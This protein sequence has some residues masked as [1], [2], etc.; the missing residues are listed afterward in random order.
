MQYHQRE[1]GIESEDMVEDLVEEEWKC[2]F[3][4]ERRVDYLVWQGE[5]GE[6]IRCEI[7]GTLYQI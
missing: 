5:D 1:Q 3:C 2:P 6:I 7:C 4:G